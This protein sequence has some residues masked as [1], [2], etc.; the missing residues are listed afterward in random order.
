MR[1]DSLVVFGCSRTSLKVLSLNSNVNRLNETEGWLSVHCSPYYQLL[2]KEINTFPKIRT[3]NIDYIVKCFFYCLRKK[4]LSV[5]L[6][7]GS[8][9]TL[10]YS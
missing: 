10:C 8:T 5:R 4:S 3:T 9:A 7:K 6:E 2:T 1:Q